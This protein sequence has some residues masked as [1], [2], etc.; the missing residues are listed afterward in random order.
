M[1]GTGI[2]W[3]GGVPLIVLGHPILGLPVGGQGPR[4]KFHIVFGVADPLVEPLLVGVTLSHHLEA[5][6]LYRVTS[7]RSARITIH[8]HRIDHICVEAHLVEYAHQG[9]EDVM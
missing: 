6:C 7:K 2:I 8:D 9:C 1:V 5:V 4:Q 3:G